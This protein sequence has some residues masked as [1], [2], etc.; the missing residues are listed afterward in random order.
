MDVP[1][2]ANVLGTL[3]AVCW[4][5]QVPTILSSG[6]LN[7]RGWLKSSLAHPSDSHQLSSSQCPWTSAYHD[8][9]MGLG[10]RSTRS[11]QHRRGL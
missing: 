10:G 3:G 11:V 8:D 4:S 5:I 6:D 7:I 1:V 2:A 9:A